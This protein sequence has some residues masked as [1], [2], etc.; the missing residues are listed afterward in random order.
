MEERSGSAGR[1]VEGC[2]IEL[3]EAERITVGR[4]TVGR[5]CCETAGAGM[6]IGLEGRL[7]M[8]GAHSK[9]PS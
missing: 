4:A 3:S 9:F 5:A 6:H 2:G 8:G 1:R 7:Q